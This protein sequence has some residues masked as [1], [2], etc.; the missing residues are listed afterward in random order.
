MAGG[1]ADVGISGIRSMK[2]WSRPATNESFK[3]RS[4]KLTIT[5]RRL[6]QG[7]T[8]LG[9]HHLLANLQVNCNAIDE[10]IIHKKIHRSSILG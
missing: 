8:A 2:I 10:Q 7:T 9:N 1:E 4:R 3:T 6:Q 5:K